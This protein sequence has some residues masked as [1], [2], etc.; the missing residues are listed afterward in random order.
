M[1]CLVWSR[2]VHP[3]PALREIW[4]RPRGIRTPLL[5]RLVEGRPPLD[6]RARGPLSLFTEP[7]GGVGGEEGKR[8]GLLELVLVLPRPRRA[9]GRDEHVED[10]IGRVESDRAFPRWILQVDVPAEELVSRSIAQRED[11]VRGF[12]KNERQDVALSSPLR[13]PPVAER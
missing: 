9:V 11:G 8:D 2:R 12:R 13:E 1:G 6:D 10:V 3:V 5:P 4:L 7:R